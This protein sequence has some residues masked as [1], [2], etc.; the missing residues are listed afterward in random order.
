[1]SDLTLKEAFKD[2][3]EY[4]IALGYNYALLTNIYDRM[5]AWRNTHVAITQEVAELT[6]SVPWKPWRPVKQQTFDTN[7]ARREIVDILFFLGS[8]C[9]IL[10]IPPEAL[11]TEFKR[12]MAN[13][14]KRIDNGYNN[15]TRKEV[16]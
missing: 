9:E 1:M 8:F 2:I 13:N 11:E 3:Q 14:Y 4:H 12:V 15:R 7:N 5:Q 6:D 10:C 16:I